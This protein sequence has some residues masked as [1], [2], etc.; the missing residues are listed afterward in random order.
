MRQRY[1]GH[2]A[3]EHRAN[4]IGAIAAGIHH[5]FAANVTLRSGQHPFVIVTANAGYWA[6]AD[7]LCTHIARALGKGLSQL[8]RVNI[9]VKRIPLATMKV[10]R[11]K[12]GVK[13]L[14]LGWRH[15]LEFDA[16]LLAHSL[17][18]AE[19]FHALTRMRQADRPR[20]VIIHRVVDLL[21]KLAI[22]LGRVGL[23]FHHGP[24]PDKIWAVA[25]GM[26]G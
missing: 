8:C 22:K 23:D 12:E 9:T 19:L 16:H 13:L 21:S 25:G 18:M 11:L 15:F 3:P 5:I 6:E 10:M 4:F 2:I 7:D 26:P 1:T 14:H 24:G 17:N 20:D